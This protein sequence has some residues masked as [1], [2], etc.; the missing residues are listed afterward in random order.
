MSDEKWVLSGVLC[1]VI[2]LLGDSLMWVFTFALSATNTNIK[3]I[4]FFLISVA[5]AG[6]VAK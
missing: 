4:F 1:L 6:V 3:V 2:A 5:V